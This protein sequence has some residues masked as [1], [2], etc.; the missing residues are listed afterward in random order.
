M[1]NWKKIVT[2]GSD[3]TLNSLNVT[4]GVTGSLLGT[5][6]YATQALSASF[7]STASF[8][9]N[10]ISASYVLN[11]VS[12]SF[13]ST[14]S[15]V[16][17]LNQN[18]IISGSLTVVTGS[19]IEF[20][21]TNTGVRI[22]NILS[23]THTITGSL[24]ATGS[25]GVAG[26]VSIGRT[27]TSQAVIQRAQTPAGAYSFIL[28][29]GTGIADTFPY[30]MIDGHGA[31]IDMRAGDPSSD[32]FG[33]GIIITANGNTSPLGEGNAIVFKNRVSFNTYT[34]RMRILFDGTVGIGVSSTSGKLHI[35]GA[36]TTSG[37]N[38]LY[39]SNATPSPL[40]VVQD[41]GDVNIS[42]GNL[43]VTNPTFNSEIY[44]NQ[45]P[46]SPAVNVF[47]NLNFS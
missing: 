23:D 40:L 14:A 27:T 46:V 1:P 30:T 44:L 22:G 41:G 9:R 10:A 20:Q 7:S 6:S 17:T 3:A 31:T 26:R 12:A 36:G 34:E 29:S 16:N 28:A 42:N 25:L 15:F 32:Q 39:I 33:G 24:L 37:T 18:V 38:A 19:G 8:V 35:Q 13:S 11:A 4:S 21:V 43:S 2:S 5:A 47:N 45:A